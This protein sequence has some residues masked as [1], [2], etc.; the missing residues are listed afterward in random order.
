MKRLKKDFRTEM[1]EQEYWEE[2]LARANLSMTR[3]LAIGR[4]NIVYAGTANDL[5]SSRNIERNL[6]DGVA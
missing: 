3:G 4:T 6:T 1:T 2:K 5:E